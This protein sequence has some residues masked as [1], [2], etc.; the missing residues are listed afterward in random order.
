ML[1]AIDIGNTQIAAG[2]FKND[3]LLAHWRLTSSINRTED[4]TWITMK[5]IVESLGYDILN[6][7][8]VAISSVVPNMTA[9]FEKLSNKYLN[10]DP[11]IVTHQTPSSIKIEYENPANVGADRICNA[12]AGYEK[13]KGPLIIVDLG[14]AT[15]FDVIDANG[16]YLGGIIAPGIESSSSIL[17]EKAARLPKVELDFPDSVIGRSTEASMQAGIMYGA[18]EMVKGFV[19]RINNELGRTHK[20]IITGGLGKFIVNKLGDEYLL[21]P[22]LTLEGLNILYRN[23]K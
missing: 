2:L 10:L 23:I 7:S 3:Q 18:V 5:A 9:T 4:E 1:L 12:V 6:T 11:V 19:S 8:G 16:T 14:T 20:L 15:T 17:H 22:F 21:E 13:Y